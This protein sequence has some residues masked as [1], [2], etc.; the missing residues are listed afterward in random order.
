MALQTFTWCP[1][2]NQPAGDINYRLST[3]QFGDGYRQT[4]KDGINNKEQSWPLVFRAKKSIA[5]DIMEF[6]DEHAGH[7]SFL[8][9]P[10][11][12]QLALWQVANPQ[13]KPLSG[14]MFEITATF[15]QAFNS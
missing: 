15:E 4:A 2:N 13:I 3:A 9:T 12:G 7:K 10:P 1:F 8:W 6:F 11:L 14:N 5:L